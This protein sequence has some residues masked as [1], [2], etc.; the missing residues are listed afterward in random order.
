MEMEMIDPTAQRG[1]GL[2]RTM[3]ENGRFAKILPNHSLRHT[4][5][6]KKFREFGI[7][8][9]TGAESVSFGNNE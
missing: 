1:P 5:T 6:V 8:Y 3:L 2:A 4:E 9:R 7:E